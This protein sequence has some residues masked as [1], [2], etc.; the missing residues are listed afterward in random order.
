M[1]RYQAI[2]DHVWAEVY[3]LT[4]ARLLPDAG[5]ENAAAAADK[6]ADDA[7]DRMRRPAHF[8]QGE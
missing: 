3:A 4:F 8:G 2:E 7:V 6:A 5:G 1:S